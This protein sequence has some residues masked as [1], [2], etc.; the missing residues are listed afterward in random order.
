MGMHRIVIIAAVAALACA[1]QKKPAAAGAVEVHGRIIADG[2]P[3]G[4]ATKKSALAAWW[5]FTPMAGKCEFSACM[6]DGWTTDNSS[7]ACGL[8]TVNVVDLDRPTPATWQV[9]LTVSFDCPF[10]ASDQKKPV[11]TPWSHSPLN[12]VR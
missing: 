5:A 2:E 4:G 8:K 6:K 10:G 7:V 12:S 3:A 1:H 11:P 9:A